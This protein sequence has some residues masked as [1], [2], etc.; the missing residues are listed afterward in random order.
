[1][2]NVLFAIMVQEDVHNYH[3]DNRREEDED[4]AGHCNHVVWLAEP[5]KPGSR[6]DI[7]YFTS[8]NDPTTRQDHSGRVIVPPPVAEFS[9]SP[10][11]GT[12][13]LTIAF[14]DDSSGNPK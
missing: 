6:N 7:V 12:A 13:P 5:V 2:K 8:T 14:T 3:A 9:V 10:V 11:N 1:M 4:H